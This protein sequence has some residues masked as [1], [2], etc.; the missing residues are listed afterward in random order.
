MELT[1]TA[2]PNLILTEAVFKEQVRL[3]ASLLN[4]IEQTEF[5]IYMLGQ[6]VE[7][8]AEFE[9]ANKSDFFERQVDSERDT[10]FDVIADIRMRVR[11]KNDP[12]LELSRPSSIRYGS[13]FSLTHLGLD[14]CIDLLQ[15]TQ[16]DFNRSRA[17]ENTRRLVAHVNDVYKE[18]YSKKYPRSCDYLPM[19]VMFRCSILART[20]LIFELVAL[21]VPE[22]M[23][24]D[25]LELFKTKGALIFNLYCGPNGVAYRSLEMFA[26]RFTSVS[27]E[28]Q[29]RQSQAIQK[30]SNAWL[31][32]M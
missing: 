26:R 13:C 6:A 2:F 20:V 15:L 21:L 32:F 8:S 9:F 31:Q 12:A 14:K 17:L 4:Q 10:T 23:V 5:E 24:I 29:P 3:N 30:I 1:E 22:I 28:W 11:N 18:L 19:Q 16:Q 27:Q 7:Q 25:P